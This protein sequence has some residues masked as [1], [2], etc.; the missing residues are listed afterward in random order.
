MTR[1]RSTP[2]WQANDEWQ[3][4]LEIRNLKSEAKAKF[5]IRIRKKLARLLF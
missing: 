3:N 2:A 1:R 5:K 4:K